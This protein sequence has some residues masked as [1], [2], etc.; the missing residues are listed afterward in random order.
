MSIYKE[1]AKLL[2]AISHLTR[3]KI[4]IELT[5]RGP[6]TVNQISDFLEIPQSTTSQHLAIMRSRKILA[7]NR[8]GYEVYYS[9]QDKKVN[10]LIE[11]LL[12]QK[13]D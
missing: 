3:I 9:V 6:C 4:V 12:G 1:N 13:I 11:V 5:K 7:N 10:T 8:K 2:K